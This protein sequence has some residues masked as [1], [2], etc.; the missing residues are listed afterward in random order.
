M[1][2]RRCTYPLGQRSDT[3]ASIYRRRHLQGNPGAQ[4]PARLIVVALG[5]KNL[6][7]YQFPRLL[8]LCAPRLA[9]PL[10][11]SSHNHTSSLPTFEAATNCQPY[12]L[13][14]HLIIL[15]SLRCTII[16]FLLQTGQAAVRV[17]SQ[18]INAPACQSKR[19]FASESYDSLKRVDSPCTYS[20]NSHQK[21]VPSLSTL[22][23]Y[24]P[25]FG[26]I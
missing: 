9:P 23:S 18:W 20:E 8:K 13:Q 24:S 10:P 1:I 7:I 25:S 6:G 14:N 5:D 3:G 19:G 22:I 12:L 21:G 4:Y 2:E 11:V 16:I 17:S 26:I 15:K